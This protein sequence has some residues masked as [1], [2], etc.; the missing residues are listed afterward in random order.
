ME[1][2]RLIFYIR[3]L[4]ATLNVSLVSRL[5]SNVITQMQA[6]THGCKLISNLIKIFIIGIDI[7][8]CHF[9]YSNFINNSVFCKDT[10]KI[11]SGRKDTFPPLSL[12]IFV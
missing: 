11:Y 2:G 12:L 1:A 10:I 4:A 6:D 3:P 5:S 9:H 7:T 8:V